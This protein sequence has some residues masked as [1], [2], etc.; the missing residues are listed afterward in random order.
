MIKVNFFFFFFFWLDIVF[1]SVV[2]SGHQTTGKEYFFQSYQ[3]TWLVFNYK[4]WSLKQTLGSFLV[5]L[6][7]VN[8][9][10]LL[11][12]QFSQ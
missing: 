9:P 4:C 8:R 11:V 6:Q 12:V 10:L 5:L 1:L 3:F 2:I 7:K